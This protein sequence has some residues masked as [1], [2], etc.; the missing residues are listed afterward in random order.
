MLVEVIVHSWLIRLLLLT[1]LMN[2]SGSVGLGEVEAG[3]FDVFGVTGLRAL[4]SWEWCV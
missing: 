4:E 3:E 1:Y 2:P